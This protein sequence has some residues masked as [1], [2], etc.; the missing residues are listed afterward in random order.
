M[1]NI[2][3]NINHTSSEIENMSINAARA[4]EG[5]KKVFETSNNGLIVSENAVNKIKAIQKTSIETFKVI[6][7]LGE[8]SKKINEIVDVIKAILELTV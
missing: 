2:S 5:S 4:V 6:N 1:Q 8:E 7:L 3:N